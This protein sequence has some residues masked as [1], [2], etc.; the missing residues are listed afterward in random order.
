M[1]VLIAPSPS[2]PIRPHPNRRSD[3]DG[4]RAVAAALVILYHVTTGRV[5]GG[6]DVFLVLSGFFLVHSLSGQLRRTG[7]IRPL[8]AIARTLSR[9]LPLA[10]VVLAAT[11]AAS[12]VVVPASRWREVAV[13]LVSSVTFTENA[14]LVHEAVDYTASNAAASPM[15][16]FWSLSVQVQ[17]LVAVPVV[18]SVGVALLAHLRPPVDGRRVAVGAVLAVTAASFAWSVVSTAADQQVAY[19]STLPRLWE[20]GVG[21]LVALLAAE[22]RPGPRMACVLGWGGVLAL[23]ACGAVL[24]GA[25]TFPGWQAGWPVL[26]AVAVLVAGG[27]GGRLGAHRLLGSAPMRWVG[28][29]SYALYLW[30]WPLLVL[31]LVYA[32]RET[33]SVEGGVAVVG[34]SVLLAAGTHRLVEQPA[35]DRL[36]LRPPAR[37]LALTLACALPL[38]LVGAGTT[39]WFDH[40][41]ARLAQVAGSDDHPGAVALSGPD[42]ATGGVPGVEPVPALTAIRDDWATLR[43]GTCTT[44]EEPAEPVPAVTDICVQGGDDRERR[45]VVVGDSHAAQWLPPMA[46]IA[47]DHGWQVVSLVRGGCNLSTE[48]EFIQE[49]WPDFEECAAWRGR[50]VDRI[51]ALEP[52]LVVSL[53]TRTAVGAEE[54]LPPGF[55][56]AWRQLSDAGI[57]VVGMR[58]SPRHELDVP[59]CLARLGDAASEC[60]TARSQVY[61]DGLLP[62]ADLPPG[63]DVLDTSSYFCTDTVCPPVIGNVRVY[64]D[65]NHVTA[66][67]MST[68]Q[69]LLEADLLALTGW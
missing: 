62:A 35:G 1:A 47:E 55:V 6:V 19:F 42:V 38:A 68:V 12:V 65:F 61:A 43:D 44:E 29:R 13:H 32:Q 54:V 56:A 34:L 2:A 11:V 16:H 57:R 7:R 5:S 14:R 66:S 51:L 69:P 30:H 67:Y 59:D 36:R 45:V 20:L 39:A 31:Y 49:G 64:M 25:H 37:A 48:S 33:P 24:D 9:L 41:V 40:Q 58:D 21:A 28:I 27:Q 46:A 60:R 26:C 22:L 50:L 17:A 4:L 52:D 3:I 53:G 8:S 15:Q 23:V 63:V 18:V 10:M